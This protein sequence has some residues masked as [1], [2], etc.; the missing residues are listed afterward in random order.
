MAAPGTPKATEMPSR[1]ITGDRRL[2]R[3]HLRHG[4]LPERGRRH[5]VGRGME[6]VPRYGN[7]RTYG[8]LSMRFGRFRSKIG[9]EFVESFPIL[10]I[11]AEI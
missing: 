6:Y 10:S 11:S 8:C 4:T 9:G 3:L 1:A 5:R 2:D 7:H